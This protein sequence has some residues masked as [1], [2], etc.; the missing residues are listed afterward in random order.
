ME[1]EIG[2]GNSRLFVPSKYSHLYARVRRF[3]SFVESKVCGCDNKTYG[4]ECVAFEQ[5]ISV[6][7]VGECDEGVVTASQAIAYPEY[8]VTKNSESATS[9]A[10]PLKSFVL[11]S[12]FN[13]AISSQVA[14]SPSPRSRLLQ[15]TCTYNVEILLN[16]CYAG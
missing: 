7:R 2:E 5:G 10:F 9:S 3:H 13:N 14:K 1:F 15:D 16:G 6:S 4:N 11:S 8:I 12:I